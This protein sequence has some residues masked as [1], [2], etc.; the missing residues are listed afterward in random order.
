FGISGRQVR[1]IGR[2]ASATRLARPVAGPD[3]VGFRVEPEASAAA[4]SP[5]VGPLRRVLRGRRGS[6]L[7]IPL[8]VQMHD[9]PTWSKPAPKLGAR[10]ANRTAKRALDLVLGGGALLLL[11]PVILAVALLV[12]REDGGPAFYKAGRTGRDGKPFR[13]YKFRTMVVNA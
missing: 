13:M 3:M 9:S 10:V 12:K 11:S 1:R 7:R 4:P 6:P 5:T 2:Q 8:T